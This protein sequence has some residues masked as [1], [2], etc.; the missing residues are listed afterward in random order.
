YRSIGIEHEGY[1]ASPSHPL[2]QY[3]ASATM[4]ADICNRHGIPKQ[5]T[6]NGGPGILGHVDA[7]NCCCH[8]THTDPGNG[9][10][11]TY[12]INRVNG[13]PAQPSGPWTHDSGEF[14]PTQMTS[15]W[16]SF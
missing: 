7:N 9:W 2:A 4:V 14:N 15:G 16:T 8:S 6:P 5:H 12:Y 13:L 3:D 11:W 1:A 10:D